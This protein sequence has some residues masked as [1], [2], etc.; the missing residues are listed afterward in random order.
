LSETARYHATTFHYLETFDSKS[1]ESSL[2]SKDA[3][4]S[5]TSKGAEAFIQQFPDFALEGWMND[6]TEEGRK[7]SE[8]LFSPLVQVKHACLTQICYWKCFMI[9]SLFLD[10]VFVDCLMVRSMYNNHNQTKPIPYTNLLFRHTFSD[11][12][13][14]FYLLNNI[15]YMQSLYKFT[16]IYDS[17]LYFEHAD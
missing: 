11:T 9:H 8:M 5:I 12:A 7:E 2:T 1:A 17:T 15:L 13:I 16:Y 14:S 4:S 10:C 6:S 3:D